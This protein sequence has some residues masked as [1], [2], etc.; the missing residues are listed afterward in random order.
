MKKKLRTSC[1]LLL[2][3][4]YSTTWAF[5][6]D[7][8]VSGRVTD[9]SDQSSLPGVNVVIK[10]TTIGSITDID[11]NYSINIPSS[12]GVLV[13]T[14]IGFLTQEIE[15]GTQS[16]INVEMQLDV[17]RLQEVVI[18][19]IGI[20]R[21]RKALG[22]AVTN[23]SGDNV[24]QKA[25]SDVIRTLSGK[26]PGVNITGSNGAP[27]SSTNI[28]IRGNSSILG[29][30]QPLFVVD[31]IP[32]DNTSIRTQNTLV[33]GAPYS[34][35]ALDID[36]NDIESISVLKGIAASNL[37]GS[38]AA[39][40]VVLITTKSGSGATPKGL[41][42]SYKT[43]YT[44][45]EVAGIP[46]YQNRFGQGGTTG[47]GSGIFSNAFFGS[48]GPGLNDI[49][50]VTDWQGNRVPFTTV[51]GN[52]EDFF[53]TGNAIENS[54][55]VVSGSESVNINVTA[56]H[57]KTDGF[58]P[59]SEYE[60][61]NIKVG[62]NTRL[63]NGLYVGGSLSWIDSDQQGAPTGGGGVVRSGFST[64]LWYLPRSYDPYQYPYLTEDNQDN[65]YRTGE[66]HPLFSAFE[67]PYTSNLTRTF[68]NVSLGYD[69]SEALSI[70]YKIGFDTYTQNNKQVF[71][72][73]SQFAST[74]NIT[75]DDYRF[76]SVESNLILTYQK[77]I[78][79]DFNI[80]VTGGHNISQ[81]AGN[82]QIISGTGIT[83]FGIDDIINAQ[84]IVTIQPAVPAFKRRLAGIFGDV[85]VGFRDYVFLNV[86][87]RQD[88]SSTLPIGDNG[89]FYPAASASFIFT[90]VFDIKP[91]ILSFG[92][93]RIGY[94]RGG[95]DAPVYSTQRILFQSNSN[96]TQS[97]DNLVFPFNNQP[98]LT[99]Q[100]AI[101]NSNLTPE[102]TTEL[103]VG[104]ELNFL[105]GRLNLD[106]S[107]FNRKT[108]DQIFSV[109]RSPSSG[110]FSQIVNAGE[111]KNE[112]WEVGL[113]VTPV[114]LNNGLTW[115][116]NA[117]FSKIDNEVVK[118]IEGVERIAVPGSGSNFTTLGTFAV[119]GQ[120][121]GVIQGSAVARDA[122]GN[123]LVDPTTG[124]YITDPD[125]T[126]IIGDPNPDFLLGVINTVSYKG[127]TL[128][129]L[130]DWK[131][132]GDLFS[133]TLA[134]LRGR[135]TLEQTAVGN[136]RQ[137]SFLLPGVLGD[138]NNPGTALTD[139]A[140]SVIP[141]NIHIDANDYFW[142]TAD[143]AAAE[144]S[145]Y[146]AT[147]IRLREVSLG[148]SLPESLLENIFISQAHIQLVGR[149]LWFNAPN[150]PDGYD[151]ET[152]GRGS[153]NGQGMEFAYVP[154]AKR[155]GISVKVTF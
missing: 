106:L 120:P 107:Y 38:R 138:P 46:E 2:A 62:A 95:N 123:R 132:G 143:N 82:R 60:K 67:N 29:T 91:G 44:I 66:D 130:I 118:L 133:S 58:I 102:F 93:I 94:G 129:A 152:N 40:G 17:Q 55:S 140:G 41:E 59:N 139:D 53:E 73:S 51:P 155:Y 16:I 14:S 78:N 28:N 124:Y 153:G 101:G 121:Y 36:P 15:V 47:G 154:N 144:F 1:L 54:I 87:A 111:V 151:P 39:N 74:G 127:I 22:F 25:E 110:F 83:V 116:V 77:D 27:G 109:N 10:G 146:D 85:N 72:P 89:F 50:E 11:G 56:T 97:L 84:N 65:H 113:N 108:T 43:S 37:Y 148:Y 13:F 81:R 42:I 3:L 35:R 100:D 5:A 114:Q 57:T 48:W 7:R 92:K 23:L 122:Q 18:T 30:N 26:I 33:S 68:A 115:N 71:A 8:T 61:T 125:N 112:G 103:E 86:S 75:T 34:N 137:Q 135:G 31:G 90:E 149:N 150:M 52:V 98:G 128:S 4:Y 49:D 19:A 69:I 79:E 32:F 12:G 9:A 99:V 131:E 64:Q 134:A 76:R 126:R 45:E 141:N 80:K 96:G 119:P 147:V 105:N 117:S 142:R 88:W 21:E 70:N 6:Q 136:V 63:S 145:V 20:E 104:T 24:Q